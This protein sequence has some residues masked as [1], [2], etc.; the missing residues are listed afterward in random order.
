VLDEKPHRVVHLDGLHDVIVVQH[1]HHVVSERLEVVDQAR[2]DR[3]QR[4]RR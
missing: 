1:Q 3:L 2:D 4:L